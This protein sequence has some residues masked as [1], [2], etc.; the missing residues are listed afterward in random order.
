VKRGKGLPEQWG[1]GMRE[2]KRRIC[3]GWEGSVG[4][5]V[6]SWGP[7]NL[8][9]EHSSLCYATTPSNNGKFL[10]RIIMKEKGRRVN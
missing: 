6:E 8:I 1:I 7:I 4:E 9:A 3:H 10:F 5:L 2:L